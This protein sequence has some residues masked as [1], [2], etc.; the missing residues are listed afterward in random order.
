M[1][2]RHEFLRL[3]GAAAVAACTSDRAKPQVD[4]APAAD[5]PKAVD[6][7]LT[8]DAAADAPPAACGSTTSAISA[9]HGHAVTVSIADVMAGVD[10]TYDITGV[11]SHSHAITITAA[12]FALLKLAGDKTMVTSTIGAGH[13]HVVT[14]T[15]V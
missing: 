13:T 9:N 5:A 2:S 15:C 14:I 4:A 1:L 10:K 8:A 11:S 12:M 3:V 6:A 7:A